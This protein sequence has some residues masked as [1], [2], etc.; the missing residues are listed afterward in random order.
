MD[1]VVRRLSADDA[2]IAVTLVRELAAK[3]VT[4]E[5]MRRFLTNAANYLFAALVEG[6]PSG[7]LL[8]HRLERLKQESYKLFIYEIDVA[9]EH[10]RKGIGTALIEQAKVTM[11]NE[12]MICAFVLTDYRNTAA[13]E[14]YKHTGGVAENGDDLMFVYRPERID[15]F[16]DR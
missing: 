12:S 15:N 8:A 10:Q 9:P 3:A 13:V 6:R 1:L 16:A 7:F 11:E 5:Y 4:A 2:E 14:F